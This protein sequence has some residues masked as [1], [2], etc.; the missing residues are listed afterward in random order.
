MNTDKG[1]VL[2]EVNGIKYYSIPR[3]EK[4]G[5]VKHMFTTRFG[6]VSPGPYES[7]NLGINTGDDNENITENFNRIIKLMDSTIDDIVVSNQLH[8]T[9]I[10][11]I[12]GNEEY[13]GIDNRK[14][15]KQ[16][17]DGLITNKRDI[18]L[19]T[20]YADCVPLF[21]LDI[22]KK[23]IGLA[24]AGW[25]GTVNKIAS[26]MVD[27]MTKKYNCAPKDILVGIG[28]SIGPCCYVVGDDVYK[29][30]NKNFTNLNNLMKPSGEGKWYLN[31][32]EANKQALQEIGILDRNIIV[33]EICTSCHTELLF[34]F[35]KELGETGRMAAIIKLN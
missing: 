22:K 11:I 13:N 8:T 14:L 19:F 9:N 23:V 2:K 25:R 35:R 33:S 20:F 15:M 31:L 3:F 17:I 4:T 30:F 5:L 34:S 18:T 21:Y 10:E 29:K 6:G 12:E 27:L 7:L 28:P 16:G 1:F 26:K 24:H 32:W